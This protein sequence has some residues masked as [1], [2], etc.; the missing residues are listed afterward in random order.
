MKKS[1]KELRMKIMELK[2]Y[3]IKYIYKEN[4][5][6]SIDKYKNEKKLKN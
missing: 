3:L 1:V 4:R 2:E 5:E 6:A